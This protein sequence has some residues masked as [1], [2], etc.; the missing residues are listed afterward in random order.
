MASRRIGKSTMRF[1]TPPVIVSAGTVAGPMEGRGPMARWFDEVVP[2]DMFGERTAEKAERRFMGDA[3]KIVLKQAAVQPQQVDYFIAGDL[4]NQIVTASFVAEDLGIPFIGVYGACSTS[5][6]GLAL[7]SALVDAGLANLALA[8]T[9]SHYQTAERQFRYPIE[10]NIQRKSTSQ[11]TAT[12]AGAVLVGQ[13][14]GKVKITEATL[15]RVIDMGVKDPN[16]MGP[17]MAPA[18][19]DTIFNHLADTGRDPG[20]YDVIITGDLGSVGSEIL[21]E[22]MQRR[23]VPLGGNYADG[24]VLL[25]GGVRGTGVGG[26]GCACS[27]LITEGFVWKR[28][29]NG[30]I[31]R[32]LIVATG[33]LQSPLTW[34]QGESVPCIAN[35]VALQL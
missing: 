34:Q 28:M 16:Q 6:Q 21:L 15:G 31:G 18:A 12:G 30:E 25:F 14:G 13:S 20:F 26:S 4:L 23:G 2:D 17:A 5:V 22:L 35:A 32:A 7:A 10:L 24:G 29:C 3:V 8:A 27:A 1:A 11:Y 33:A 9:S 19:A